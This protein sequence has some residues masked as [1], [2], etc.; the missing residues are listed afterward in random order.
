MYIEYIALWNA[1]ELIRCK[2]TCGYAT[3]Y[4]LR[5]VSLRLRNFLKTS[6][7]ILHTIPRGF[8]ASDCQTLR[9][10]TFPPTTQAKS[11][12]NKTSRP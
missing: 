1:C 5:K 3:A 8:A 12:H 11:K 4:G 2:S 9:A 7:N 6:Y 10:L